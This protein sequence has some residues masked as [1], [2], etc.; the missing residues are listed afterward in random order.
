MTIPVRVKLPFAENCGKYKLNDLACAEL[1]SQLSNQHMAGV[2]NEQKTQL[3]AF[4][5]TIG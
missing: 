5:S 1:L 2:D 4:Y 3:L